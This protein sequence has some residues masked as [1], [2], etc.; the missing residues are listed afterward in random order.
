MID[1]DQIFHLFAVNGDTIAI[2]ASTSLDNI[3]N[4]GKEYGAGELIIVDQ[5]GSTVVHKSMDCGRFVDGR[6]MRLNY[7]AGVTE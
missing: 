6:L 5:S 4:Y 7:E 2:P 1:E 3:A